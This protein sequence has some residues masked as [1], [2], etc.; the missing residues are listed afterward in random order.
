MIIQNIVLPKK[1]ICGEEELY[2]RRGIPVIFPEE[3][4]LVFGR[5][6]TIG[7]D[8]YMNSF[9]LRKWVEYTGLRNLSLCLKLKGSFVITLL[10]Y[11]PPAKK[12]SAKRG[13]EKSG[14]AELGTF[15]AE[16]ESEKDFVFPYITEEK[17]GLLAFRITS[18]KENGV[19][20]G[21]YY[22][23]EPLPFQMRDI[24]IAIGICTFKREPY[25][26]NNMKNL[27]AAVLENE[28]SPLKD[29]LEVFISDNAGT[30]TEE[31]F[32]SKKI[33]LFRNK[34]TGGSG[35]FTR[36]MI[37]VNRANEAGAGFTHI[38]LMDDDVIFD[39]E[40]IYRTFAVL[41]LANEKYKDAFV[42]G[43]MFRTDKQ[44]LQYASGEIWQG[45]KGYDCIVTFNHNLDLREV[46][47]IVKN[48]EL[49]PANYQGWW[50][51]AIP[52]SIC[53]L[54]NLSMPFFIKMDDIEYSI[55]NMKRLIL[56]NGINTWHEAFES[57][58]SISNEYYTFRNTLITSSIYI[59][60]TLK[61]IRK[62]LRK[63]I[64]YYLS[65]YKYKEA[66]LICEAVEDFCKGVDYLKKLDIQAKHQQ[67]MKNGYK[68][69]DITEIPIKGIET[70]YKK[71]PELNKPL[72]GW[73]KLYHELTLNGLLLPSSKVVALDMLGGAHSQTYRAK[74]IVRYEPIT[75]KGF[76]LERSF[77]KF[78]RCW[79]LYRRANAKLTRRYE[80]AKN[81]FRDRY[82]E[83]IGIEFW[84]TKI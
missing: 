70:I 43:A 18:K 79:R 78:C 71:S 13:A 67:V 12:E 30:L 84:Q 48:E 32:G 63:N 41:S 37:E 51:C 27:E 1:E 62:Y 46:K 42:G 29:K 65:N 53:R 16:S 4:G 36:A 61:E 82:R 72:K 39:P 11:F 15:T 60:L 49:V 75:K 7:F 17:N 80:K 66:E 25:V 10:Q 28:R 58:Y 52:M 59:G 8:T 44:Y 19:L 54:D 56:L 76:V 5:G 22:Q 83:L 57:K 81:D 33:H 47:N 35:G 64:L 31:D 40:S 2:F 26:R 34:N 55:R 9:S 21:G 77:G 23:T 73:K 20:Y 50:Y 38:L 6:Q 45:E 69:T 24:K 14:C 3:E 74:Y 68:L